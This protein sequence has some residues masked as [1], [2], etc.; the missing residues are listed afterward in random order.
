[1]TI[2]TRSVHNTRIERIWYDVT[3][4]FGKKWKNFFLDL[5]ANHGLQVENPAHIWL[6]HHLFLADINADALQWAEAWNCHKLQLRGERAK[7][8]KEMF[9]VSMLVDGPR[10]LGENLEV[11]EE[12]IDIEQFGID[13]DVM[14]D[15]ALFEHHRRH[16]PDEELDD[17][18]STAP[19]QLSHVPCEPPESPL[20]ETQIP[21]LHVKLQRLVDTGSKSMIVR[22][23]VWVT[24][25]S[26]GIELLQQA[27]AGG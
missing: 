10:G 4:G 3:E 12:P 5:E 17:L 26:I 20:T 19:R 22:R 11:E 14:G 7:S 25:L 18:L 21:R 1:M 16:N 15:P 24:A 6:L 9:L 23:Q 13:W 2:I 8:P 27:A